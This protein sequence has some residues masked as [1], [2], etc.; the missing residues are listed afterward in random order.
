MNVVKISFLGNEKGSLKVL[1][2]CIELEIKY[3]CVDIHLHHIKIHRKTTHTT[4]KKCISFEKRKTK[5]ESKE[6]LICCVVFTD[7]AWHEI[8][9]EATNIIIIVH[10]MMYVLGAT[11][12]R[13]MYFVNILKVNR[14]LIIASTHFVI[15]FQNSFN[16]TYNKGS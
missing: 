3:M 6:K 5:C 16:L 11:T 12:R 9:I 13:K 15:C 8:S 4:Q 10:I 2:Y 7:S 14:A 1:C